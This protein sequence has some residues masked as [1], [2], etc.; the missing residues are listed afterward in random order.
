MVGRL[1][2]SKVPLSEAA[3]LLKNSL[4]F[5]KNR[6]FTNIAKGGEGGNYISVIVI[7]ERKAELR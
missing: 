5:S 4:A 1:V 6:A 2:R 3:P 7:H